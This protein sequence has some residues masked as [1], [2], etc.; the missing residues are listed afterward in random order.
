MSARSLDV[1]ELAVRAGR[2]LAGRFGATTAANV[3]QIV[4]GTSSLTYTADLDAGNGPVRV[5]IKVAPPGLEPVRNRDVLRQVRILDF[6][7][8]KEGVSVPDVLGADAGDPPEVPPLFVMSFVPGESYEPQL[9]LQ[10]SDASHADIQARAYAAARMAAA[11]HGLDTHDDRLTGERRFTLDAEVSRWAKVFASVEDDLRFNEEDVRRRLLEA[12][13]EPRPATV[14]HGDWRL[15]NML[16]AG[17]SI[18]AVIDWEIWS[19]GDPRLDL[20]WFLL[21]ADPDHPGRVRPDS[22]LPAPEA[23]LAE[24][25]DAARRTA[26]ALSWFAALVRYKQAAASAL[27]IKNNRKLPQPGVDVDR[28]LAHLPDLLT[29][30]EKQLG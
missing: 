27:I 30:A 19:M 12:T 4:G 9:T 14:I 2:A 18:A 17:P 21:L 28:M 3:V 11:L 25:E 24:Y 13:P 1:A 7:S 6:L 20:A 29:A 26:D 15:G 22:G 23:L 10:P 5:V 8:D 16:C